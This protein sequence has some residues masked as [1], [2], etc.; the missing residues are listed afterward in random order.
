MAEFFNEVNKA[1]IGKI[2]LPGVKCKTSAIYNSVLCEV[3]GTQ[4]MR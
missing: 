2:R 4:K 3:S 1:H